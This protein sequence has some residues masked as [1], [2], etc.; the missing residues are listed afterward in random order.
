MWS[1]QPRQ[2][3]LNPIDN[4][5]RERA[6]AKCGLPPRLPISWLESPE[7]AYQKIEAG[8]LPSTS[9]YTEQLLPM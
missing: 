5:K 1:D 2:A 7:G 6:K 8:L 4:I 3:L 9:S